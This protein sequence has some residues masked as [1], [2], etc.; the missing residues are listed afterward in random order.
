MR[1]LLPVMLVLAL[2]LPTGC[3]ENRTY[4]VAVRNESPGPLT[5]GLAKDGGKFEP[6]WA[7]PE[8]V[9]VRTT[10]E[11]ERGW[12]SVVVPPGDVRSA[13]PVKGNFAGGAQAT[14]RVYAGELEL[15]DVLAISRRSPGRVDVPLEPGKNAIIIREEKGRLTYERVKLTPS[16]GGG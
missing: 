2:L 3:A 12:D 5:V 9:V 1:P 11:D 4:Q 6:Q 16:K 8:E 14:L 7:S 13:G 15:S 10:S